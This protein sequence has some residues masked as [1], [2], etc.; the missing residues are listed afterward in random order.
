MPSQPGAPITVADL[1]KQ[2]EYLL[3]PS[4]CSRLDAELLLGHLLHYDRT[5]IYRESKAAVSYEAQTRFTQLIRARAEGRPVAQLLGR[6]D[7]WSLSFEIDANVLIPRPETELLVE[8]ALELIAS[9]GKPVLADLGTGSG[10]IATVFALERPCADI[11]ATDFSPLALKVAQRNFAG[12]D[13]TRIFLLRANWLIG[14]APAL[15]DLIAANPPY[16]SADDPLL[17]NSDIRFEPVQALAAG[18]DGLDDLRVIVGQ[19]PSHL[20]KD[21]YLLVEHGYNQGQS[22]R[23]LFNNRG[24]RQITTIRDLAGFER[25]TFGQM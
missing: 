9:S 20:K 10:A 21:G 2:G 8:T 24:F 23:L 14:L 4:A 3:R 19:A 7:F 15:F 12:H 1:V 5:A 22:V 18:H 11:I 6:S 13:A 25:V 17:S 16:V